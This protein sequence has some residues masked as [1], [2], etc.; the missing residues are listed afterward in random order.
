MLAGGADLVVELQQAFAG[1]TQTVQFGG[2]SVVLLL[3]AL[4]RHPVLARQVVHTGELALQGVELQ[5]LAVQVVTDLAQQGQ[6]FLDLDGGTVEQA[7]DI[8]QTRFVLGLAGKIGP[9]LLQL[10]GQ[11]RRVVAGELPQCGVAG[12][13]QAGGMGL[14][15]VAGDQL[16]ERGGRQVFALQLRQLVF[17]IVDAVGDIALARQLLALL[18]QGRPRAGRLAHPGAFG[19]VAGECIQQIELAVARQQRLVLVLPV[20]LHQAA[21]QLGQLRQRHAAPVDPGAGPAVGTDDAPQLALALIVQ[22]VVG[23]PGLGGRA[24]RGGKLG[25]QFRA[26]GTMADHAAVGAQAR[27]ETQ[28]IDEQRLAGAGF[29]RDDRHALAELQFG[30]TDDGEVLDG[31]MSEHAADCK[32]SRRKF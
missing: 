21:G 7:V 11:G 26:L 6:G 25:R 8:A 27:Q 13:D 17:Q 4:Q 31:E 24:R 23:Q 12:L 19:V 29:T 30:G 15:A 9:H 32:R 1:A 5:G 22:F 28:G 10:A 16:F 18:E 2:Q 14:A 3:Q 20:D